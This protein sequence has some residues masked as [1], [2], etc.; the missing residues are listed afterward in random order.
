VLTVAAAPA[1]GAGTQLPP[2]DKQTCVSILNRSYKATET[3]TIPNI[4][5]GFG[6]VR[7]RMKLTRQI[8]GQLN[9][10]LHLLSGHDLGTADPVT[11]IK[12]AETDLARAAV[13]LADHHPQLARS[14]ISYA[15]AQEAKAR[16]ALGNVPTE[17]SA[18]APTVS[19]TLSPGTAPST[20]IYALNSSP[21]VNAYELI[22]Q[23][24]VAITSKFAPQGLTCS[25]GTA[26][27]ILVCLG[28]VP[29]AFTGIIAATSPTLTI[30]A[31]VSTDN[32]K[33]FTTPVPLK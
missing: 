14:L 11:P 4:P 30:S 2:A 17:P 15:L 9:E 20:W 24:G 23:S 6:L 5:A 18:G 8:D 3:W 12:A 32:G 33:T 10:V 7:A 21:G 28:T 27:N 22:A 29:Q 16:T 31:A 19:G 26:L 25:N 1:S 13:D